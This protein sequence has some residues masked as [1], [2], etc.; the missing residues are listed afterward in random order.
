M[1]KEKPVIYYTDELN[2]EF[3]SAQITPKVI[4]GNYSYEHK[5]IK[6][7]ISRL[8][9]YHILAK[10]IAWLFLKIRYHHKIVNRKVLK[11]IGKKGFYL[12]GNHT[13]DIAD[14]LIPTMVQ[15]RHPK[16]TYVIVHPNNVS[17]PVLGKITPALGALP[18]PGDRTAMKNFMQ[19]VMETIE[20]GRCVMIYPEA[21][22]WP[23]YTKIRPFVDASFRYP[24]QSKAPVYCLTNTYQKKRFGKNPKMVTY[25]DGPFYP[26]EGL[27]TKDAKAD[28][29]NRVYETMVERSKNNTVEMIQYIKKEN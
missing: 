13:N 25:I 18:L 5:S 2:E 14:A 29:R 1:A 27:S 3:S 23:F 4:D 12:F 16:D 8:F 22:I 17:M 9:W 10:P 11:E 24:L 20:E 7:K 28:L 19:V 6:A 15:V 26:K 21:H